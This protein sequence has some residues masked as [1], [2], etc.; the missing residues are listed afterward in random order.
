MEKMNKYI[1][2]FRENKILIENPGENEKDPLLLISFLGQLGRALSPD[3]KGKISPDLEKEILDSL[4]PW[5]IEEFGLGK[6]WLAVYDNPERFLAKTDLDL[7]VDQ[8]CLYMDPG[9]IDE[10]KDRDG[11]DDFWIKNNFE[12][13][14]VLS[15]IDK[16]EFSKISYNLLSSKVPLGPEKMAVL[17]WFLQ[18]KQYLK[19]PETIPSKESLCVLLDYVD[20]PVNSSTDI[21]RYIA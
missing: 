9:I 5:S 8:I 12:I 6:T 13:T 19:V 4:V 1:I 3:C 7:F 20:Y 10:I 2:A 18:N 11:R 15:P 21:L 14:K 16:E 17:E